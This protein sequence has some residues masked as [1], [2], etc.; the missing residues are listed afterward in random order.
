MKAYY[1]EHCEEKKEYNRARY[2]EDP[3]HVKG[4]VRKSKERRR[5][6]WI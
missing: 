6:G 1:R 5:R 2:R 4:I 3:E